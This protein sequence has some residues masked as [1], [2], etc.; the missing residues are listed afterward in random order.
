M[1][2]RRL[3]ESPYIDHAPAN[4]DSLFPEAEVD[5]LVGILRDVMAR[6]RPAGVA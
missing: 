2:P 1:E 3:Y 6:A 5:E 4:P